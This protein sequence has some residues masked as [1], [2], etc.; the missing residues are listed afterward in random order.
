MKKLVVG[1]WKLN[2]R[3]GAEAIDLAK[4]SDIEG[5]VLCPPDIFLVEVGETIKKASLGAQDLFW[6]DAAGI[7]GEASAMQLKQIGASY[8]IVGHS[9]RR[10]EFKETD[11]V[12]NYKTKAALNVDLKTILCIGED[13]DIHQQGNAA[14]GTFVLDQLKKDLE[15]VNEGQNLI[16]VYE[17]IWSI[18]TS[19]TGLVDTPEE[20]AAIMILIKDELFRMGLNKVLVIYGGSVNGTT[21]AGFLEQNIIDGVLVGGA[22]LNADEFK[23]VIALA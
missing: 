4:A 18:S 6:E 23:Q 7:T 5:V 9:S 16:V 13:L 11:E 19:G 22:S 8:V 1:N 14:V 3:T 12:I 20:A 21:A 15:G 17:P 10:K 2:P